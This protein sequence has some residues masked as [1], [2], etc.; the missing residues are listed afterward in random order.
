MTRFLMRYPEGKGKAVTFSYDDGVYS[1]IRFV[2]IMDKYGLRAT[3]NLNGGIFCREGEATDN[4]IRRMTKEEA[5]RLYAES[6]HEV[7]L[8]GYGHAHVKDISA[9]AVAYEYVKDREVLEDMFHRIIRGMA[10]P[11]GDVNDT[12]TEVVR[13]CGILYGRTTRQTESFRV[14]QDW[15]LL[16]PTCHHNNPRLMELAKQFTETAVNLWDNPMLFYVWGHTYEFVNQNNWKVIEDFA[17]AIAGK[18]DTWYATNI[19]I[20]E[21]VYAYRSLVVSADSS[22]VMNPTSMP[23]WFSCIEDGKIYKINPGETL[24]LPKE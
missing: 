11:F 24:Y 12:V 1:D 4:P 9:S 23:I 10:Y 14:P 22:I 19:A 13:N 15:V 17:E 7:A 3:F 21:Y 8:H 16:D 20:C 5:Y 6:N 18:E 2:E